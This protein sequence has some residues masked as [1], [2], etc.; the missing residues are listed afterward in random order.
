MSGAL[1]AEGLP[2]D[3]CLFRRVHPDHVVPDGNGSWRFSSAAFRD[4]AMSADSE[5]L[6]AQDG[7]DRGW[8]LIFHPEY[9]LARRSV[10]KL[11][12]I[13]RTVVPVPLLKDPGRNG[14]PNPYHAEARG[15]KSQANAIQKEAV[16]VILKPRS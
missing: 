11:K 8:S 16:V 10:T 5:T 12:A 14:G 2:D 13:G 4:A 15:A 6:L 7:F 9:S 1:P 3:D